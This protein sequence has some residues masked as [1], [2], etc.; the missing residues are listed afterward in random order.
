MSCQAKEVAGEA[1]LFDSL[2]EI[3]WI[4]LLTSTSAIPDILTDA[5]FKGMTIDKEFINL[6]KPDNKP[7][8]YQEPEIK[9]SQKSMPKIKKKPKNDEV[10]GVRRQKRKVTKSP[11]SS[12]CS[13]MMDML[14]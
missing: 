6:I 1:S 5:Y 3:G 13:S 10:E 14:T 11:Y 7:I 2:L 12:I 4:I 9:Y 8:E